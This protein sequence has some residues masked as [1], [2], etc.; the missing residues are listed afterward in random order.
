MYEIHNIQR[1]TMNKVKV[2]D[3]VKLT[4]TDDKYTDVYKFEYVGKVYDI[5]YVNL[6]GGFTQ[7]WVNFNNGSN[8]A[9]VPEVGDKFE[10]LN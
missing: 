7:I 4:H 6:D 10:I 9:I 2:G 3:T 8:F 5:V 1:E